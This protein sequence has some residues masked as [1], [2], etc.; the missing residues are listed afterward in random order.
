MKSKILDNFVK[1]GIIVTVSLSSLTAMNFKV[2]KLKRNN[3]IYATGKINSGDLYRLTRIYNKLPRNK[4]SIVVFNSDGGEMNTGI[5]IGTFLKKHH[6]GTAVMQNGRCASSCALAFLGGRDLYGRKLMILPSNAKL[7]YH[8]FYYKDRTKVAYQKIERDISYL[9]KYFNYVKAPIS[10]IT[11]ALDTNSNNMYWITRDNNHYLPLKNGL[12]IYSASNVYKRRM[13]TGSIYSQSKISY[14]KNYFNTV[15]MVI[16]ANKGYYYNNKTI[17]LNSRG[18][19]NWLS[20]NLRYAYV[21]KVFRKKNNQVDAKV[22]YM[23]RNGERACS[24]NSYYMKQT[25]K[26]WTISSKRIKPCNRHSRKVLRKIKNM[27]P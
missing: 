23:L 20:A 27:L 4:Q 24:Q 9:I 2:N 16:K 5:K 8:S 10:L 1:M 17:A 18:Y 12:N 15:N 7:G 26:G 6:I 19:N 25:I 22:I 11:K 14:I 13:V 3:F 21:E